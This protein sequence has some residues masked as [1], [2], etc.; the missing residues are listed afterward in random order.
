MMDLFEM[1]ECM[2]LIINEPEEDEPNEEGCEDYGADPLVILMRA[3]E[4][5]E[6]RFART[7]R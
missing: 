4:R 1:V 3:E 6:Y 5:G 2:G 7:S